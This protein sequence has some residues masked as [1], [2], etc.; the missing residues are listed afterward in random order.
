M[1]PFPWTT[2]AG[3]N[4]N[5]GSETFCRSRTSNSAT[6]PSLPGTGRSELT[7]KSATLMALSPIVDLSMIMLASTAASLFSMPPKS[8][9]GLSTRLSDSESMAWLLE[10]SDESLSSPS[11]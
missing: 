2:R 9:V 10:A 8:L 6:V 3:E 11:L 7:S 4:W 5:R 1:S